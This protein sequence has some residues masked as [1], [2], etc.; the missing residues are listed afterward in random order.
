MTNKELEN[1][2]ELA[3]QGVLK[4]RKHIE[5]GDLYNSIKFTVTD[6]VDGPKVELTANDYIKYLDKGKLLSDFFAS[7]AF[8]GPY[9]EYMSTWISNTITNTLQG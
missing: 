6:T 5:S 8:L 2:L 3:L 4:S 9:G 1:K 7:N